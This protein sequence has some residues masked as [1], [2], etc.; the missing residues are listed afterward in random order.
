M[1]SFSNARDNAYE[2]CI[3]LNLGTTLFGTSEVFINII[4]SEA[5]FFTF[6]TNYSLAI[7]CV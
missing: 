2:D 3:S 5:N 1:H 7:N 4:T 6:S